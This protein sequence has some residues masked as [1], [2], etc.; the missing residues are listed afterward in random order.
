M[1]LA[2]VVLVSACRKER[3]VKGQHAALQSSRLSL[4]PS[5]QSFTLSV[6]C[7]KH[8]S[9]APF[10][11]CMSC[12]LSSLAELRSLLAFFSRPSCFLLTSLPL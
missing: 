1:G 4:L 5:F 3:G 8:L 12:S 9:R 11:P 6:I 10:L 2:G 7:P